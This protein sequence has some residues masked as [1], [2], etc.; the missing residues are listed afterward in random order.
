MLITHCNVKCAH[1]LTRSLCP[2]EIYVRNPFI[3]SFCTST[4]AVSPYSAMASVDLQ[5][6]AN[7]TRLSRLLVDKG[8]EALRN[9]FDGI[10]PPANLPAVL[11]ANRI[12]LLKLKPRVIND[13]QWDLLYPSSGNPPDSKTFDVTLLTVLFRNICGLPKTGWG[14]TPLDTDRSMQANIVRMKLFRNEVYAH[15]TSTQVD[16]ATFESLWKKITQALIE[17][18]IPQNDVDELKTCPLGPEEEVHVRILK[19]WKLQEENLTNYVESID[20]S[21]TRLKQ[22]TEDGMKQLC[23]SALEQVSKDTTSEKSRSKENGEDLLLKLAKHNFKSKISKKVKLFLP[24]TREWL[25]EKVDEWF[26]GNEHESRILLLT[27]G[28]GFGKS[29]FAAKVCEDFKKKGKLAACHFCDFNDSNLRNPMMMLQSLASQMCENVVGFKEKLLD[30]L[31]RPHEVRSLKDAF[32]IY[33]QNPLNELEVEE[34]SIVVIDGLDESAA[35]DKNEIVNLIGDYFPDLPE[36]IKILVTSRPVI[37]L[38]KLP[39]RDLQKIDIENNDFSNETD[40][41]Y[42]LQ[43]FLPHLADTNLSKGPFFVFKELVRK[44]EGSFLF[45]FYVQSELCK[46]NLNKITF[47]EIIEFLPEGLDSLYQVYFQR[48]EAELKAIVHENLDVLKVLEMVV[49]S[50]GPLPLN[51]VTQALGLSPDCRQTKN[52]I[53]KVNETVSC[54]LYVSED[55]HVTVFHKSVID[56]LLARGCQDHEYIVKI[57]NG[58]ISLWLICEQVFKEIKENVYSGHELNLTNDVKYALVHGFQHLMACNMEKHFFW[59]VDVVIVHVLLTIFSQSSGDYGIVQSALHLWFD[60][61]NGPF[62]ISDELR[63]KISWHITEINFL[64]NYVPGRRVPLLSD[65]HFY[66]LQSVLTHSPKGCFSD[67]EKNIAKL[68]LSKVPRFVEFN[69]YEVE[70]IPVVVRS[71]PSTPEIRTV[72]VSVDKT[73][74]AVAQKDGRIILV[75]LPSLA[76]LWEYST[77]YEGI[78]CCTFA[79]DDSFL[80]FGKMETALNIAETKEVPFFPT[81]KETFTS[82]AFSPNGKRLLTCNGSS[83]I[84]LWDVAKQSLLR[85]LTAGV[86]IYRCAISSTEFIIQRRK[87][88]AE[89]MSESICQGTISE[90]SIIENWEARA[91]VS[92]V[93]GWESRSGSGIGI[94]DMFYLSEHS[95]FEEQEWAVR[96][97]DIGDLEIDAEHSNSGDL[98]SCPEQSSIG[99]LE[100]AVGHVDIREMKFHA[101]NSSCVW[102]AISKLCKCCVRPELRKISPLDILPIQS[103]ITWKCPEIPCKTW[104]TGIYNSVQCIFALGEHSLSVIENTH[105]T[106]LAAWNLFVHVPYN[107]FNPKSYRNMT[108]IEDDMWLYA[109]VEKLIVFRTLAPTQ[110]QSFSQLPHP[111]RVLWSSFSPNGCRLATCTS[112]SFINIW[113]VKKKQV[114]QRFKSNHSE[115]PF[116]CWWSK[117]FLFVLFGSCDRIFSL[118]KYLVDVNLNILVSQTQQVALSHL[119]VE[120]IFLSEVVDFTEGFL[121]FE[122]RET[123]SVKVL[124]VNGVGGPQMVTLPKIEPEM[125]VTVSPGACFVFGGSKV[126]YY[127]WKKNTEEAG[128][129]EVF[130]T[131]VG[132]EFSYKCVC[133]FSSDSKVAVVL[134]KEFPSHLKFEVVDLDLGGHKTVSFDRSNMHSKLFCLHNDRIVIA[135]SR[136][137][138]QFFDMDTGALLESSFQRYLTRDIVTQ[139]KLS[140]DDATLAFPKINGDMEFLRLCIPQDSLLS[141]IKQKAATEWD[142]ARKEFDL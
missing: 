90:H 34:S 21:V 33:L 25:L 139:A 115:S 46:H 66:Y 109:D 86:P 85:I 98:I 91:N 53:N 8:T 40:L 42:Y 30:Q 81:N 39:V 64:P 76:K 105:S 24:G 50:K 126:K 117:E 35:E 83:I 74:A 87:S 101:Q 3:Y 136:Q 10:H 128:V 7:F 92:I 38:A 121:I 97:A 99:E 69:I 108:A 65:S 137:F 9:T 140:P 113:N 49:A 29:V 70:I 56:W 141:S 106:T 2:G 15:V 13:L 43:V 5:E 17:L 124:D 32:R 61:L 130:H 31:Q 77:E 71:L 104:S 119:V 134:S 125:S 96:N 132:T 23:Q 116:A 100:N 122:Y 78:S 41:E 111:T 120:V 67:N 12:S 89:D 75:C 28:P 73:T 36:F 79:P 118:S 103:F 133:C 138:I 107:L 82:C 26:F 110:E 60:I 20:R 80:L 55:F 22:I 127:I 59:L 142:D 102:N 19:D 48:L 93:G 63:A 14:A 112:D 45:A 72:G 57:S 129:Y 131:N 51:F 84:M 47:K 95:D 11:T 58:D 16:N 54:L 6:K 52:I 88:D 37:S 62:V 4:V 114:E 94:G 135:A 18:N 123:K 1:P 27:A 44:C 68:L